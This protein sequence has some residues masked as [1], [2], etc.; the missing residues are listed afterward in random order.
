MRFCSF[1]ISHMTFSLHALG[2]S[3][4]CDI[5]PLGHYWLVG[6]QI[7]RVIKPTL[8]HIKVFFIIRWNPLRYNT[9][10]YNTYNTAYFCEA[11]EMKVDV[12]IEMPFIEGHRKNALF[13]VTF[14]IIYLNQIYKYQKK[15]ILSSFVEGNIHF[16]L[17]C[18]DCLFWFY[19]KS[20]LVSF[21]CAYKWHVMYQNSINNTSC[22]ICG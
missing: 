3:V 18:Y 2:A 21:A 13:F 11:I 14:K 10:R 12:S 19:I 16:F 5:H 15:F 7:Y 8:Y 9:P 6:C 22:F 4:H 20:V 17:N 1:I